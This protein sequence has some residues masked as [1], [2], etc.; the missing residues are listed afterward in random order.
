MDAF[1]GLGMFWH[2]RGCLNL[3]LE[4]LHQLVKEF[5]LSLGLEKKKALIE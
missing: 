2:Y 5:I 1:W 3:P 4:G